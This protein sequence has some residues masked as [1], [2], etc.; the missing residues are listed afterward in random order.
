MV[1]EDATA[2]VPANR[3]RDALRAAHLYYIQ[4]LTMD[5][6][7]RELHTSRSSVSRLL[8]FA[9]DTGLVQISLHTPEDDTATFARLLRE[10]HDVTAHVV[11][12]PASVSDIERLDRVAI[13]SARILNEIIDSNQSIG[14]AWGSTM[15]AV[16]RY[17]IPKT[18]HDST[19]VQ[20]NG[21]GNIRSSGIGYASELLRRF[22]N[23]YDATVHQ[24][25]VPAFFDDPHT[26]EMFWRER[27]T[28]RILDMQ[29][30]LDVALFSVGSPFAEVPSH[31]HHAGFLDDRDYAELTTDGVVGD[32]ATVFFRADGSARDIAINAR[33]TGPDFAV[34]RR[35]PRRV[36]I[37]AG[38]AK[39]QALRGALAA[40]L[41]TDLVLDETTAAALV[42]HD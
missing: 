30:Q 2:Y 3:Q 8:S 29:S 27:G 1:Q 12:M 11:P 32:V 37:V 23:A 33:S 21:S 16:S 17:L 14:L 7:A 42:N 4:N 20:L 24:F 10:R 19:F 36:C 39:L 34:L 5:A 6:I 25:P 35:T 9:R 18:T 41:V 26:R 38:P 31:V 22:A 40:G 28:R 15:S 13:S